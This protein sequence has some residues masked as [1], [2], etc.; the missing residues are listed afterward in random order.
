MDFVRSLGV[1]QAV[2]YTQPDWE[3][4]LGAGGMRFDAIVDL[5]GGVSPS[6]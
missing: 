2:D 3:A 4:K 1:D 6:P 5:V